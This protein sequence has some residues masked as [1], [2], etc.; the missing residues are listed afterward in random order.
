MWHQLSKTPTSKLNA[1][2]VAHV[3]SKIKYAIFKSLKLD[4]TA[5]SLSDET[6]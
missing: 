1:V 6:I 3:K 4:S 2:D 5:N